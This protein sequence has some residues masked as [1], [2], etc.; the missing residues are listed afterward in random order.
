MRRMLQEKVQLELRRSRQSTKVWGSVLY[1]FGAHLLL[2][3]SHEQNFAD[4]I[5]WKLSHSFNIFISAACFFILNVRLFLCLFLSFL[6]TFLIN[7]WSRRSRSANCIYY[8]KWYSSSYFRWIT[9]LLLGV[10]QYFYN[11]LFRTE[12]VVQACCSTRDKIRDF[13]FTKLTF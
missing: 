9:R 7:T 12:I 6:S 5:V 8:S 3:N 10:I 13:L 4:V 2:A 11:V 1:S